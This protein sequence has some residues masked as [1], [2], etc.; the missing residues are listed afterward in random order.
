MLVTFSCHNIY[1]G[2]DFDDFDGA[3]IT[4]QCCGVTII[5][6]LHKQSYSQNIMQF[7]KQIQTVKLFVVSVYTNKSKSKAN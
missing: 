3:K 4:R 6:Q 5:N 2:T 1:Y 7:E